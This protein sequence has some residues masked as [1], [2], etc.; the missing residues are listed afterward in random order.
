MADEI[1]VVGDPAQA[2]VIEITEYDRG[3]ILALSEY[4]QEL[5]DS[6]KIAVAS[7]Q[8]ARDRVINELGHMAK[9]LGVDPDQYVWMPQTTRF[10][11]KQ[12]GAS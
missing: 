9:R 5:F 10:V 3:R 11:R 2:D 8:F 6:M 4:H 1:P 7:E 12:D